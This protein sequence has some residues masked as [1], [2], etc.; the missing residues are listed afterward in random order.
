[1]A[2]ENELPPPEG[3]DNHSDD[4]T[5]SAP[6]KARTLVWLIAGSCLLVGGMNL[7]LYFFQCHHQQLVVSW[8]RC[9]WLAI[10]LV[11]GIVLLV[12]TREL[13]DWINEWLDE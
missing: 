9:L 12:K 13:A 6:G 11:V 2:G 10:P 1:M 3:G 4:R 5:D 8:V 7:G